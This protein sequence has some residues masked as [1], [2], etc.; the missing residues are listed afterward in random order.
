MSPQQHQSL[1]GRHQ[2]PQL[3]WAELLVAQRELHLEVEHRVEAELA[4]CLPADVDFHARTGPLLPPVGQADQHAALLQDRHVVQEPVSLPR[5]PRQRLVDV[6]GIHQFLDQRALLRG[7]LDG[8]EQLDERL[9]VSR[10]GVLAQGLAQRLILHP[11]TPGHAGGIRGQ[12]GKRAGRIAAVLRQV[13]TDPAHLM[14]LRRPLLQEPRQPALGRGHL[15]AHP[16]V[17]VVP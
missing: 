6:A 17:Q 1:L 5:R 2:L 16:G 11:P 4:L 8:R 9:L 12:E 10:A 13:K 7:E 3:G 14:P 15:A